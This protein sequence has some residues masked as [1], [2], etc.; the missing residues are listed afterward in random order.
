MTRKFWAVG[1]KEQLIAETP[2][3]AFDE[4]LDAISTD[5]HPETMTAEQFQPM[6]F[7]L[8][9]SHILEDALMNIDEEYGDP[10]G[11]GIEP[12][13]AM[14]AAAEAL[15][16]VIQEE[17][18]PWACERNGEKKTVNVAAWIAEHYKT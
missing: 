11:D 4:Y 8:D 10:D 14:G 3:E 2:D 17:Y 7:S 1:D 18:I 9:P 16:K 5:A 13:P 6:Q 15:C 12:T